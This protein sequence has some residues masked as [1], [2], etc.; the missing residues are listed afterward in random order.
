MARSPAPFLEEANRI[1]RFLGEAAVRH[2]GRS[3]WLVDAHAVVD[4]VW[5]EQARTAAANLAEGTAGIGWFL[6]RLASTVGDSGMAELAVEALVHALDQVEELVASQRLGLLYGATGVAWAAIDAGRVLDRGDLVAAGRRAGLRAAAASHQH[7]VEVAPGYFAG[8]AGTLGG[9]VALSDAM[10][11][12][13]VVEAAAAAAR[14]LVERSV[15][16][17][18]DALGVGLANGA[19]GVGLALASWAARADDAQALAVAADAFRSERAWWCPRQGWY[20]AATQAWD[21]DRSLSR[22]LASG[23]AGIGLARLSA[24]PA[25]RHLCLAEVGAVIEI[26]REPPPRHAVDASIGLGASGE[27]ELLIGAAMTL[28]EPVHLAAARQLGNRLLERAT[29]QGGYAYGPANHPHEPSLLY[30][31]AGTAL[32]MMRLEDPGLAPLAVLP[33]FG[34]PRPSN[35]EAP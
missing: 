29:A 14:A 11:D 34:R 17:E 21:D 33:A 24:W 1:G 26:V 31:L 13:A 35:P 16:A 2:D 8:L 20:G 6:A 4:G 32:V 10:K 9:L 3:T 15:P 23:A 25:L 18:T 22:S 19:S 5:Q 28:S 7:G 30:G 27:I 12:I